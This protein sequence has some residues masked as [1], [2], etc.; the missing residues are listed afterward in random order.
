M[1]VRFRTSQKPT[2]RAKLTIGEQDFRRHFQR[3]HLINPRNAILSDNDVRQTLYIPETMS[4][5][6]RYLIS[7]VVC[8]L[9]TCVAKGMTKRRKRTLINRSSFMF[10]PKNTWRDG[11]LETHSRYQGFG[12]HTSCRKVNGFASFEANSSSCRF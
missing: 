7:Q 3:P 10:R 6:D 9:R 12:W 4:Y 1:D 5:A 2:N 8:A 11:Y